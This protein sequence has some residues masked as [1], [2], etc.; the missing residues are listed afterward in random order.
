MVITVILL[1]LGGVLCAGMNA[2]VIFSMTTLEG[3]EAPPSTDPRLL[4]VG[5]F[6]AVTFFGGLA[7]WQL[8]TAAGLWRLKPWGRISLLIFSG[9]LVTLQ[10]MGLLML[11]F[12][13]FDGVASAGR[14]DFLFYVR[15]FLFVF[16]AVPLAIG[17]WW[18]IYFNRARAKALFSPGGVVPPASPLPVSITVIGW[19]L[20]TSAITFPL[21][22][23][24]QWP[25]MLMGMLL[26]GW[27]AALVHVFW[28]ALSLYAGVGLLR[29]KM[30]GYNATLA[31]F[32]A[33]P[34]NA[35]VFWLTPGSTERM[36]QFMRTARFP[37]MNLAAEPV[38]PSPELSLAVGLLSVAI[39][40][41]F[42][43]TRRKKFM[44]AAEARARRE[45]PHPA[46][47][48]AA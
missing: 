8:A 18:L 25:A 20:V 40:V 6:L 36:A 34:I 3:V 17:I 48:P 1:T 47:P 42:L 45:A 2:L 19:F 38:L 44:A 24:W 11:P 35:L 46:Q 16:Y 9:F 33:G 13:P 22:L 21:V 23:Y 10:G 39:P 4:R 31:L 41:Y 14:S 27:S 29:C 30:S 43:L 7:L 26:T 32:A 12:I 15:A 5:L 37:R 28:C